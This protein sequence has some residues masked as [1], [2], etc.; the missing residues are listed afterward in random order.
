MWQPCSKDALFC[1]FAMNGVPLSA[2]VGC[3]E[4]GDAPVGGALG[5]RR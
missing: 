1:R 4:R 5:V 2:M 3:V